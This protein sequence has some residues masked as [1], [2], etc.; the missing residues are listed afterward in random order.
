MDLPVEQ[1][2]GAKVEGLYVHVPFCRRR[3]DYCDFYSTVLDDRRVDPFVDAV[4]AELGFW[5]GRLDLAPVRTIFIGGGTPTALPPDALDRLIETILAAAGR[6]GRPIEEFT[7][8]ANPAT[9]DASLAGRLRRRGVDRLSLGAQ[10]FDA[11]QLARLG[12]IHG[13]EATAESVR[14]ARAAGFANVNLDLMFAVPGQTPAGWQ[15]DLAAALALGV[16]HL[17]CYALTIEPGTPLADQVA[18]GRVQ[19]LDDETA[20]GMYRSAIGGLRS[21]GLAQYE[22]SNF[23]RPGRQCRHNLL[24]WENRDWLGLGPGAASHLAGWRFRRPPDLGRYL[25]S[26]GR[27]DF[28]QVEHLSGPAAAGEAAML[29]LRLRDGLDP[30]RFAERYGVD[31]RRLWADAIGRHLGL[32]LLAWRDGRLQITEAAL[33]VADSV[34]ADFVMDRSREPAA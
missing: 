14:I 17:S 15:A 25:A 24:Y 26:P 2:A 21:A 9:V 3:C 4:A 11:A 29:A 23:A 30:D 7:V 5:A 18:A 10:S 20:A 6:P 1:L 22:I 27:A 13:P 16:E 12:R 31:P 19:P 28:E 34:L 32:G 8:E 33:P